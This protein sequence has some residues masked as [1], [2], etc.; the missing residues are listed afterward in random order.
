MAKK[1]KKKNELWEWSKAILVAVLLA[2]VIRTVL[3]AP[4]VVDGE[5][6]Q[7]TL[8][9]HDRM[10]VNK[11]NYKVADPKRFDIV[12]FHAPEGKDYIKRVIG[13][14]GE[15]VEYKNDVLYI[16]GKAYDEPYLDTNKEEVAG[17]LTGDFTATVPDGELF[18]MGDNRRNSR[19][20]R[21]PSVGT[22]SFEKIIGTTSVV[23]WP[24]SEAKIVE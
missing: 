21:D 9:D 15:T 19:D 1:N 20:S 24:L 11:I 16:N 12:V 3:F 8:L 4:I 7:S 10:I 17:P 22:V 2:F 23:Y 6:M 18:V 5:S 13:L 14:P